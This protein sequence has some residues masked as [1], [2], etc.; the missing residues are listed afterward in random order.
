MVQF[1]S[2]G[3][4]FYET[5]E[6]VNLWFLN[7][8]VGERRAIALLHCNVVA[9]TLCVATPLLPPPPHSSADDD[10]DVVVVV[11]TTEAEADLLPCDLLTPS[12]IFDANGQVLF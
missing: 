12:I 9:Y 2:N 8:S 11:A 3:W 6:E 1:L 10:D 4:I 7:L 5:E